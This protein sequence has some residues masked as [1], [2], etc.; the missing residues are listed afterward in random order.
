MVPR[1]GELRDSD[2]DDDDGEGE[3]VLTGWRHQLGAKPKPKLS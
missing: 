3:G 2:D 1:R